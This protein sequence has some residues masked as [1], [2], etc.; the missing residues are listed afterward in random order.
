MNFEIKYKLCLL[1]A[2]FDKG[3]G[4]S[5]FPKWVVAVF[6]VG[7]V[8]KR[9]YVIVLLGA[10]LFAVFCLLIGWIWYNFN[11]IRAEAEVGNRYNLFQE[12][13][14]KKFGVPKTLNSRASCKRHG[15]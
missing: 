1:K 8:V 13:L 15:K 4:L 9:N 5:S 14:R 6:G 2:F 12:Q 3:Y 7:E 11:W 10:F